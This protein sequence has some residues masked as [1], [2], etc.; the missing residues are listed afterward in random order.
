MSLVIN[1]YFILEMFLSRG[2]QQ[3]KPQLNYIVSHISSQK[4]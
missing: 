1:I 3:S 2:N 4:K